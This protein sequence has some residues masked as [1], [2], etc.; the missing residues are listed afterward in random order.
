MS[1]ILRLNHVNAKNGRVGQR[2]KAQGLEEFIVLAKNK[3]TSLQRM[4]ARVIRHT[5]L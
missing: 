3:R 4:A 1:G 5:G 2:S